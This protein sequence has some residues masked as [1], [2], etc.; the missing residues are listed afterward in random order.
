MTHR[1]LL[2]SCM[3]NE[4][5]SVLEWF[6]YH[7]VIG[8]DH[9]L[10]YTNDCEDGTDLIWRHLQSR[11]LA[12]HR[13]NK[14]NGPFRRAKPQTRALIRAMDDPVHAD[15]EWVAFIDVDEFVNIH[16]GAGQ[17]GDLLAANQHSDCIL[18]NWRLFGCSGRVRGEPGLVTEQ[19]WPATR[20][21]RRRHSPCR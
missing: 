13:K 4:G 20:I 3:R 8:V 18:L 2:M 21:G 5:A 11:G 17:V 12:T 15:A 7:R 9:F 16:A 14:A 19:R 6:A 1:V 10:V